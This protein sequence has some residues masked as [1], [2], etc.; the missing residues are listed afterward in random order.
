VAW[1]WY[2]AIGTSVTVLLSL[3]GSVVWHARRPV[4]AA[5][6]VAAIGSAGCGKD[7][8]PENTLTG[9]IE[10]TAVPARL[11][12]LRRIV[13]A[14]GTVSPMPDGDLI[15]HATE[16]STVAELP[17]AE[18]AIVKAGDLI[19]RFEV[20]S[21]V[22]AIQVAEIENAQ[23]LLRVDAAKARVAQIGA[24]VERGLTPRI[25]LD[26][27]KTELANAESEL[28]LNRAT[29]TAAKRVEERSTIRATFPGVVMK[30]W[31][32]RGDT[33]LG[34]GTDP[35]IRVIDPTRVQVIVDVPLQD[36]GLILPGQRATISPIGA[37]SLPATVARTANAAT[38]DAVTAEV[39]LA[40]AQGSTNP[41][42]GTAVLAEILIAEVPEAL[43]VPTAAVLRGDGAPHVLVAGQDNR[44]VRRDIR[45]GL[46]TPD[47][48]Q[49]TQGLSIGEFVITSALTELKEG[50]LVS[51]ARG[52]Q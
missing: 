49:I 17:L 14:R 23:G 4:A 10:V 52:G 30:R 40:F 27:A 25:E 45:A 28:A 21:R 51:F 15:V 11:N 46:I 8:P 38:P 41:P 33:V 5:L 16:T 24:M 47:L 29:L 13:S 39:T 7:A 22:A 35:V 44:V 6:L 1:P 20:P 9:A 50:D 12:V 2:A 34:T 31:H 3:A 36:L 26:A 32:N 18:G 48:T 19:V 42:A 37:M 43:V